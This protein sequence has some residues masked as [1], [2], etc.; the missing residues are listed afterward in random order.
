[1]PEEE[2]PSRPKLIVP[3]AERGEKKAKPVVAQEQ[4]SSKPQVILPQSS[5]PPERKPAVAAR[6][7][8]ETESQSAAPETQVHGSGTVSP[9]VLV[10]PMTSPTPVEMDEGEEKI[11]TQEQAEEIVDVGPP[12]EEDGIADIVGAIGV[13]EEV[14][15]ELDETAEREERAR[16]A[17]EERARAIQEANARAEEEQRER[18]EEQRAREAE[19]AAR[20]KHEHVPYGQVV[21]AQAGYPQQGYPAHYPGHPYPGSPQGAAGEGMQGAAAMQLKPPSGIP[22]WALYLIGFL[23]GAL[24]LLILFMATPMGEGLISRSLVGKGWKPPVKRAEPAGVSRRSGSQ[25][26]P[27]TFSPSV[28]VD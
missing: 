2:Q 24:I 1:M 6:E 17:E 13:A 11:E 4:E 7:P 20:E 23:S 9:K 15:A 21:P 19:E 10:R 22:G 12:P 16:I 8:E 3:G 26:R 25:S 5:S 14:I 27:A 18:E 28:P